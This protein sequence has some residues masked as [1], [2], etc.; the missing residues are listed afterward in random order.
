[1]KGTKR[2]PSVYVSLYMLGGMWLDL[3]AECAAVKQVE[4]LG[5]AG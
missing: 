1:M 5:Y 2:D 3:A 4:K